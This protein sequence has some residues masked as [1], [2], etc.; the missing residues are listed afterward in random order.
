M[1]VFS[2]ATLEAIHCSKCS[3]ES[4]A[5]TVGQLNHLSS[6]RTGWLA[7]PPPRRA[8]QASRQAVMYPE[9]Y[10]PLGVWVFGVSEGY[11]R[12]VE[13]EVE[14]SQTAMDAWSLPTSSSNSNSRIAPDYKVYRTPTVACG[15]Y[16]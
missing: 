11:S 3:W 8:G 15:R 7:G 13:G 14:F 6:A 9:S 16:G 4:V 10:H 2:R 12:A 1:S 5:T